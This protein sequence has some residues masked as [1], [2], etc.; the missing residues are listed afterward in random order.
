MS[1]QVEVPQFEAV[2][3]DT[4]R[5]WKKTRVFTIFFLGGLA[6]S[7]IGY[8]LLAVAIALAYSDNSGSTVYDLVATPTA[9]TFLVILVLLAAE[10]PAQLA[11]ALIAMASLLMFK[12]I[13]LLFILMVV[14]LLGSI[15]E[16]IVRFS[17]LLGDPGLQAGKFTWRVYAFFC[18]LQLAVSLVCW[19]LTRN[20]RLIKEGPM[21]GTTA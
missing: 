17:I 16:F 8:F 5:Q 12:R 11:A 15:E 6:F 4:R 13:S 1:A 2:P 21:Q 9:L 18:T 14:P 7:V 20:V 10:L 19:W 3:S